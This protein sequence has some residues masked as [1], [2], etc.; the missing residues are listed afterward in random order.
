MSISNSARSLIL[1]L[2]IAGLALVPASPVLAENANK[3]PDYKSLKLFS[4]VLTMVRK[5]YVKD[6]P[7]KELIQG[8]LNGMLQS[9]DP[10]SSFLTRTCSRN[11]GTRC[12]TNSVGWVSRS[13]WTTA[14]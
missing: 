9:L 6:V 3:S 14:S 12:P 4:D 7:D 8:A 2:V 1:L 11:C 5:N 10:H 13:R